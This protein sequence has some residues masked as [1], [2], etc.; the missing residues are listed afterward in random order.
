MRKMKNRMRRVKGGGWFSICKFEAVRRFIGALGRFSVEL[1]IPFFTFFLWDF[2]LRVGRTLIY[3]DD[4]RVYIYR[5][6]L[7][8]LAGI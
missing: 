8:T 2:D 7:C 6:S 4:K 5:M 3:D 1:F